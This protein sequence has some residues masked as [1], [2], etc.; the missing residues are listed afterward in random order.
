V[1]TLEKLLATEFAGSVDDLDPF[2]YTPLHVAAES[3]S[4]PAVVFLLKLGAD[5]EKQTKMHRS[6]PIH[7]AAFEGHREVCQALLE[8]GC[9][10]DART[11][12]LR[13]PLYQA[14]FRG[15]TECVKVLLDAGADREVLA[16]DGKR[17]VDIA[18]ND[19]VREL[20]E[21]PLQKKKLRVQSGDE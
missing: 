19:A 6:R 8:G 12:D 5:V 17:A 13:T 7:Y 2:E 4:K 11:D 1:E 18:A 20:L 15:R 16:Q 14:S 10:P 21:Q 9:D 3:G